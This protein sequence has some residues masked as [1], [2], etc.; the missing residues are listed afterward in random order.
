[1]N[2]RKRLVFCAALGAL[3]ASLP[4]QAAADFQAQLEAARTRA[5]WLS[6]ADLLADRLSKAPK[7]TDLRA[8]L[9]SAWLKAGDPA[10][11]ASVLSEWPKSSLPPLSLRVEVLERNEQADEAVATLRRALAKEPGNA[12]A[13]QSLGR[14]LEAAG[15]T[16]G[17][18]AAYTQSIEA[19][20]TVE[21]LVARALLRASSD[22]LAAAQEDFQAAE[23]LDAKNPL[24]VRKQPVFE[25]LAEQ[26][27]LI[28][29]SQERLKGKPLDPDGLNGLS[30]AYLRAGLY[31]AALKYA[32]LS[33][34][35]H[36]G[37]T[38]PRI[39]RAAATKNLNSD[40]IPEKDILPAA[41]DTMDFADLLRLGV[42]DRAVWGKPLNP[43]FLERRADLLSAVGQYRL[44]VIDLRMAIAGNPDNAPLYLKQNAC[45]LLAG[46]LPLAERSVAEIERLK[47]KSALQAEALYQLGNYYLQESKFQRALA[48]LNESIAIGGPNAVALA[49]RSRCHDSMGQPSAA[50]ADRELAKKT[51]PAKP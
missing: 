18:D 33:L 1:M 29:R 20:A 14:L 12:E 4:I 26:K 35:V 15:D 8:E 31:S 44:G 45:A 27:N 40:A 50:A 32:G 28:A 47:P 13:A 17:A 36:P 9:I 6:E 37:G 2:E 49:A 11:A 7:D 51:P 43:A 16:A 19:E 42:A 38:L 48:Y 23:A 24:V 39:V 5:D 30:V 34:S 10:S 41:L 25:R 21:A 22:N 3:L 46:D